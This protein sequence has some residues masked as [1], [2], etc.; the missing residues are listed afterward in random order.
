[1][2]CQPT[3]VEL[4]LAGLDEMGRKRLKQIANGS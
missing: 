4:V 3:D 1:L 2:N